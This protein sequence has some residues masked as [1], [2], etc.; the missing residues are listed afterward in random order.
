MQEN[1]FMANVNAIICSPIF[2]GFT[3]KRNSMR[4]NN[5]VFYKLVKTT[6]LIIR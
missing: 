3:F 4:L 6:I 1:K 5:P 2:K